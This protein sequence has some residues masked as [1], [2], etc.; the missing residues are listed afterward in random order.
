MAE[1][2]VNKKSDDKALMSIG[3]VA[4]HVGITTRT[5]RYYEDIG[6]LNSIKRVDSGRRIYTEIDIGRLKFIGRLKILGLSL[7]E[8]KELEQ[9]YLKHRSNDRVLPRLVELLEGH[10]GTIQ[11][12][13]EQLKDLRKDIESY[14]SHI[15]SKI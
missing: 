2:T 3:E 6:L 1:A 9:M 15:K 13:M 14:Q 10:L 12:R 11:T 5:I 8:M 7:D 4:K